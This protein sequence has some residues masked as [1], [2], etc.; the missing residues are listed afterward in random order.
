MSSPFNASQT[1]LCARPMSTS[2][3]NALVESTQEQTYEA[4]QNSNEHVQSL[5]KVLLEPSLAKLCNLLKSLGAKHNNNE[6]YHHLAETIA[7]MTASNLPSS[8]ASGSKWMLPI[9]TDKMDASKIAQHIVTEVFLK[10]HKVPFSALAQ[11]ACQRKSKAITKLFEE[12][13][14]ICLEIRQI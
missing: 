10:L 14:A 8:V 5:L 3:K 4:L 2:D 1:K 11:A 7:K 6:D 9:A 13:W 12:L